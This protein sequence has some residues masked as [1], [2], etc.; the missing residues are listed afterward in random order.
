MTVV[1]YDKSLVILSEMVRLAFVDQLNRFLTVTTVLVSNAVS[2]AFCHGSK[3]ILILDRRITTV[4]FRLLCLRIDVIRVNFD[5][6]L[7][8]N[9][10]EIA[11]IFKLQTPLLT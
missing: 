2:C 9:Y 8:D 4:L 6:R 10:G 7:K 11:R 1:P 5:L 3:S